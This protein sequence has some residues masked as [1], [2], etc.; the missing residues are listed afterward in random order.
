MNQTIGEMNDGLRSLFESGRTHEAAEAGENV[1]RMADGVLQGTPGNTELFRKQD[2]ENGTE[3]ARSAEQV[4]AAQESAP[5]EPITNRPTVKES[6]IEVS[7]EKAGDIEALRQA[8][9]RK[10]EAVFNVEDYE[11]AL[12]EQ[13][14][15]YTVSDY[16]KDWMKQKFPNVARDNEAYREI[17]RL[18]AE[19]MQAAIAQ[20]SQ[21]RQA[22]VPHWTGC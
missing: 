10:G 2:E 13:G 9:A 22:H 12:Q 18:V 19:Q 15:S 4:T 6:E 21:G 1:G 5:S 11:K 7:D 8:L 14:D 20:E 3:E 16:A 17:E